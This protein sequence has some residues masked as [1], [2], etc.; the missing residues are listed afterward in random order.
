M[1]RKVTCPNDTKHYL[2]PIKVPENCS[3]CK[4]LNSKQLGRCVLARE[5]DECRRRI[6]K[7]T[8]VGSVLL[9]FDEKA[10][11]NP[12]RCWAHCTNKNCRRWVQIDINANGGVNTMLMPEGKRIPEQKIPTLVQGV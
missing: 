10:I 2:H 4:A 12:F 11:S 6:E 3:L 1:N 7:I 9:I 5:S 8:R